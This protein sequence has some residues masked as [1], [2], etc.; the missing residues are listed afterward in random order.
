M[1]PRD[2]VSRLE[3][4][5]A[6]G[7]YAHAADSLRFDRWAGCFT[8]DA[9]LELCGAHESAPFAVLE[10]QA[11]IRAY[12]E[13][14]YVR[15]GGLRARHLHTDTTFLAL[16]EVRAQTLT[17]FLLVLASPDSE[18]KPFA[19]GVYEDE[20]RLEEGGWRIC[21]RVARTD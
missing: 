15:R 20:W 18:P 8:V 2:I 16:D 11:T 10:S 3:I 4:L 7:C 19:S 12:L 9:R 6:L 5:D 14:Q 17:H 21:H 13:Q 1:D